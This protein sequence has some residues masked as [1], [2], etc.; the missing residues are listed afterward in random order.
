[1]SITTNSKP[2]IKST[3]SVDSI[4]DTIT[5]PL[6]AKG[7]IFEVNG[8]GNFNVRIECSPNETDW[9]G[10]QEID[11]FSV[12]SMQSLSDQINIFKFIRAKI[13]VDAGGTVTVCKIHY[14]L[15]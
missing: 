4:S 10:I 2:L 11:P 12:D 3:V 15:R 13:D 1:M 9:Y 7:L 14:S 5:L 6:R 8:T